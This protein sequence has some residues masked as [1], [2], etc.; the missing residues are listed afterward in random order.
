MNTSTIE[1]RRSPGKRLGV[2][3]VALAVACAGMFGLASSKAEASPTNAPFQMQFNDGLLNLGAAFVGQEVLPAPSRLPGSTSNLPNW[4]NITDSLI[5][6]GAAPGT[7]NICSNPVAAGGAAPN[8]SFPCQGNPGFGLVQATTGAGSVWNPTAGSITLARVAPVGNAEP[9]NL[10]VRFPIMQV[11]SPT[12]GSPVPLTLAAGGAVTGTY[13]PTT[14][15]LSLEPA[16]GTSFEAR[17]LVG[18]GI[19]GDDG[20]PQPYTYCR[21]KLPGLTLSTTS[22]DTNAGGFPATLFESGLEGRGAV[23]GTANVTADSDKVLQT[24]PGTNATAGNAALDAGCPAVNLVTKGNTGVWFGNRV[25]PPACKEGQLGVYPDCVDPKAN[26]TNIALKGKKSVKGGKTLTLTVR[27][28]N[29]GTA[30]EKVKVGIFTNSTRARAPK[31]V[32]VNAPA[33]TTGTK[34]VK[35]KTKKGKGK[36]VVSASNGSR[37]GKLSV[38]IK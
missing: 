12:T 33:G 1:A 4:W 27:V 37:T 11:T 35:I 26:I 15:A 36:V 13:D 3:A 18:L 2:F 24:L 22:G 8:D 7:N 10:D 29:K 31:P 30:D 25:E 19:S 34:K 14:G 6:T 5:A 28:T 16:A 21:V 17:V 23:Q 32:T 38:R 9:V 20:G